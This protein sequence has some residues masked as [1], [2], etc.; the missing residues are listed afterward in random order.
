VCNDDPMLHRQNF[1]GNAR[2]CDLR[3]VSQKEFSITHVQPIAL[4]FLASWQ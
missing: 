4:H 3:V 1:D 2:S